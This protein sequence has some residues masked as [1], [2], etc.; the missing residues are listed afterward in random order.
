MGHKYGQLLSFHCDIPEQN[1]C[2][3]TQFKYGQVYV[4]R[5]KGEILSK[6]EIC[7]HA[8]ST[9]F[10]ET[11]KHQYTIFD[12]DSAIRLKRNTDFVDILSNISITSS[13]CLLMPNIHYYSVHR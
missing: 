4:I 3:S 6:P 13:C 12:M 1:K 5:K 11:V 10:V 9:L 8:L 7:F 2:F